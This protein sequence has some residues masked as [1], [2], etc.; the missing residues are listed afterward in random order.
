MIALQILAILFVAAAL[1]FNHIRQPL[2]DA[3]SWRE[4]STATIADNFYRTSW[5]IFYPEVSWTGPGPSY[6]GR[7]FQTASYL[8]ALLYQIFGER[9]WVGR[10]VS[11]L[12]GLTGIFA[13]Y[14]LTRRVWDEKRARIAAAVMAIIPGS[15]FIERS[16]LPD[17]AM[18]A[19]VVTACWMLVA[20]LQTDGFHYLLLAGLIGAWGFCTKIPGLIIGL[21]MA[22]AIVAING[23]K[24][25]VEAKNLSAL[26]LFAVMSLAPV[27]AYYFWA[28]HLAFSYPP[29][30]FAGEGNWLWDDGLKSWLAQGY[31]LS[32]LAQRF[33]DWMWTAPVIVLV[34]VGLLIEFKRKKPSSDE[35]SSD[36][37]RRAR[38]FFHWWMIAGVVFYIIGAKELVKN[39]WNFHIINPAAAALAGSAI[40]S[41][42]EIAKRAKWR[43]ISPAIAVALLV[44]ILIYGR[45]GL[46]WMYKPYAIEGRTLGLAL[47]DVTRSGDLVI[48]M[49]N[50]LGDPV[51]IYYSQRR[52]WVFPPAE[53]G[54][55][56]DELPKDD[57]ESIALFDELRTKGA[58]W[59][60]IV[61]KHRQD[62]SENHPVL[63]EYMNRVC[64][65]KIG[66]SEFSIYRI[67]SPE[68]IAVNT[69]E[70]TE[71]R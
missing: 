55:A 27:V 11:V 40:V 50:D 24:R 58:A 32:R 54:R 15:V 23:R 1:R 64:E 14:Q 46:Q 66:N 18:V 56:W 29:Y 61:E 62:L 43:I 25:L 37:P 42:S 6:Q 57:N 34:A 12:F 4:S 49:A 65:L 2:V 19:L 59:L 53:R 68:E 51:A 41:I 52:G 71:G 39:P 44:V 10:S 17:A 8:A 5:N 31:F 26:A 7:E 30:H 45:D 13:L 3:F 38:W 63:F 67:R 21:P 36:E 60:G 22:Y 35:S 69:N 47:H 16:F 70:R 33:K 48:T 9:D 20:Y 28:R